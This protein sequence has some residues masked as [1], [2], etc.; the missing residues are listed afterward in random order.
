MASNES[1][2]AN[3]RKE[4]NEEIGSDGKNL[5][6]AAVLVDRYRDRLKQLEKKVNKV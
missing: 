5:Y 6:R 3:V 2:E 4:I 1:I